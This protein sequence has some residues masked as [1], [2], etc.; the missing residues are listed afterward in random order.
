MKPLLLVS[1]AAALWGTVGVANRLMS[2]PP[3]DPALAGLIRTALG[4]ICLL[5]IA[6]LMGLPRPAWRQVPLGML[7]VFAV[8][9]AVFQVC[10]FAAYDVVG[11][12]V[13]VAVT[14]VGPAALVAVGD[15]VWN[16]QP[17]ELGAAAAIAV[18]AVG[19]IL[20]LLGGDRPAGPPLVAW[21]GVA[22]LVAAVAAFAIVAVAARALGAAMP[23]L[24]GVGL[25]LVVTALALTA[26]VLVREDDLSVLAALPARDLMILGYTGLIATG[27]AYLAFALGMCLS[28]SPTVGIAPTLIEPGVAAVLAALVLRERLGPGEAAGC[29]LMLAGMIMLGMS[30]W[31]GFM[32]GGAPAIGEE[33]VM[34]TEAAVRIGENWVRNP[35][36]FLADI[37]HE[38][39][40]TANEYEAMSELW[41]YRGATDGAAF[42]ASARLAPG[43]VSRGRMRDRAGG[44]AAGRARLR[45]SH[46]LRHLGEDARAGQ[47]ERSLRRRPL[48]HR[49]RRDALR[50]GELRRAGVHCRPD[51]R[52][53]HRA[54]LRGVRS[55]RAARRQHRVLAPPGF[56]SMTVDSTPP[57]PGGWAGPGRRSRS[58]NRSSTIR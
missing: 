43:R 20:A 22:L 3:L 5:A 46:R 26:V 35:H 6:A 57:S 16:R 38:F 11:V 9:G 2:G 52:R 18:A 14:V 41:D 19:V 55:R 10:L 15:A 4:G 42:F 23:V 7:V 1:L 54:G 45:R 34:E 12:T 17:P 47:G 44:G 37:E 51:L 13:T 56:S 36:R 24:Q 32:R 28:R 53:L 40:A 21:G 39:D 33:I 48:P 58:R 27:G 8:A 31:R 29:G 30:E 50:R 49:Y 25:G